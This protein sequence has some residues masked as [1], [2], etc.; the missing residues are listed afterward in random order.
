M[1][2]GFTRLEAIDMAV[3]AVRSH[4]G[5]PEL[6]VEVKKGTSKDTFSLA[7]ADAR[8]VVALMMERARGAANLTYEALGKKVN[9][10]SKST[11]KSFMGGK[12]DPGVA[13]L[14]KYAEAMDCDIE[15]ILRRRLDVA[16]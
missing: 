6:M 3:D 9:V 10:V 11:V 14:Q 16:R 7:F 13:K 12:H 8:P 4:L 2:Q 15:I 1:T 5:L